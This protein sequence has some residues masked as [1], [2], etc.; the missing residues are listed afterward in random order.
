MKVAVQLVT[1]NGEAFLHDCLASL[2]H[3]SFKDWRI[4]ILD[5]NSTDNS[6]SIIKSWLSANYG[7]LKVLFQNTGFASG[8]NALLESQEAPY[9]LILNQDVCLEPDYLEKLVAS[10]ETRPEAGCATGC[11]LRW[12]RAGSRLIKTEIMDSAG[13]SIYRTHRTVERNRGERALNKSDIEEIYGAPATA[14]L[15]RRLALDEAA[16]KMPYG[17]E[18][19]DADFWSYKE[20]VDLAYRLRLLGWQSIYVPTA[21]GY[22]Y[23][24][25]RGAADSSI[26]FFAHVTWQ[27]RQNKSDFNKKLSYRNHL[28]F[29]YKSFAFP[30]FSLAWWSTFLYEFFKAAAIGL[31]EPR[32]FMYAWA[33]LWRHRA[34]LKLKR[35]QIFLKPHDLKNIKH[36][37]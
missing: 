5:N 14:A 17:T 12:E 34:R 18:W 3:Q 37:F 32:T 13:L 10:M 24:G 35:R 1:W 28:F 23:R 26:S 7:E 11:L 9:V 27:E 4:F 20:D 33:E 36:F 22:H 25:L 19:F 31:G 8:H 30:F 16:L 2:S 6:V 15:Y 21:R 29:L